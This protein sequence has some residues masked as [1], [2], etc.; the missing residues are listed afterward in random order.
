MILPGYYMDIW[1]NRTNISKLELDYLRIDS[2]YGL[3]I[4]MSCLY[5]FFNKLSV[6]LDQKYCDLEKF[7]VFWLRMV[8][9]VSLVILVRDVS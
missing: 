1:I 4:F 5:D 9:L 2:L 7:L 8:M 3:V 6:I